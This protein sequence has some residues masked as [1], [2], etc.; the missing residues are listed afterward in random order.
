VDAQKFI[1]EEMASVFPVGNLRDR[2]KTAPVRPAPAPAPPIEDLPRLLGLGN[3]DGQPAAPVKPARPLDLRIK[4]AGFGGQGVLMLGEVLAE[5]G[6][7]A[8][9]EVS[10]L[11]S[12]GPEMRSGTSNCHVRI[13]SRP[14]D[15]PVVSRSNVLV[16]MNEPSLHKFLAD[17]EPGGIVLYNTEGPLPDGLRTDVRMIARH[18]TGLADQIGSTKAANIVILGALLEAS[19]ILEEKFVLGALKK[20]VKSQR[21]FDLD[22]TAMEAGRQEIRKGGAP[23]DE[24]ELWGV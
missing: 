1:R 15:S 24:N 6:L 13:G 20:K 3:G 16:A 21:W 12:Y 2:S 11:P 10:W 17:V 8:G 7:G 23:V 18:F 9:Y 5:A 14:V 22:V 4:V 19:G